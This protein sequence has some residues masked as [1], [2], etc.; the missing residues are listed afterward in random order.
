LA[1][2]AAF[3]GGLDLLWGFWSYW[4]KPSDEK[5]LFDDINVVLVG[6][7]E[8][9]LDGLSGLSFKALTAAKTMTEKSS[10]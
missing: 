4:Q 7:D 2:L 1:A 8:V 10:H 5:G 3:L 6:V 9:L